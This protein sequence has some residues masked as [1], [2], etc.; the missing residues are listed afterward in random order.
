MKH[1]AIGIAVLL[2]A[3]APA[4][5]D[6]HVLDGKPAPEISAASWMNVEGPTPT[7]ETLR[8]KVW[9]LNFIGVH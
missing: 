8:G 3:S 7:L 2:L 1:W 5:A 4:T 6:W 9:L